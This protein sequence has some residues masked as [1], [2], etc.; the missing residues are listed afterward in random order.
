MIQSPI[1]TWNTMFVQ[2]LIACDMFI[3]TRYKIAIEPLVRNYY[4]NPFSH[5]VII[6]QFH[7]ARYMLSRNLLFDQD[8]CT[9]LEETV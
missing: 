6:F 8:V 7:V 1:I 5:N 3:T 4:Y 2:F 9:I